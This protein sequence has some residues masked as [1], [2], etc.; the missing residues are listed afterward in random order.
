[1]L[2]FPPALPR[3]M[4][5]NP[6]WQ[7]HAGTI[8]AV[9]LEGLLLGLTPVLPLLG[10]LRP[11]ALSAFERHGLVFVGLFVGALVVM[12]LVQAFNFD[13]TPRYFLPVLPFVALLGARAVETWTARQPETIAS[14]VGR[15]L[16][17]AVAFALQGATG[18]AATLAAV[19]LCAAAVTLA[20]LGRI[21]AAKAVAIATLGAGPVVVA[22]ATGLLRRHEA[23]RL[24]EMVTRLGDHAPSSGQR[25]VYT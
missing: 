19:G 1:F 10:L 8:E 25:R 3:P 4:P 5:G 16:A 24:E 9:E 17:G 15:L 18:R 21:T 2:S 6:Y 22:D 13:Q 20:R 7:A 12:P 14:T 11:A 23:S